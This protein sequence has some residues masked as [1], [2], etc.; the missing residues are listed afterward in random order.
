MP[1]GNGSSFG[2]ALINAVSAAAGGQVGEYR[3]YTAKGWHAQLS[4]LTSSG[5]GYQA[6]ADVGLTATA[7]TLKGWLAEKVVPTPANRLKIAEAYALMAGHWPPGVEGQ[8]IRITGKVGI[9]G[10]VRERGTAGKAAFLVDGSVG[11]WQRIKDEWRTGDP[12]PE[13]IEGYFIEDL[14]EA[15]LGEATEEW[16]L[17]GTS[18][19]VVI[20]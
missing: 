7:K 4:K 11:S 13:D 19:T 18:Y 15:D 16:S 10:D 6:A 17:P 20:G 2:E 9:G 8:D 12:D 1:S 14:L 3:S 5:R